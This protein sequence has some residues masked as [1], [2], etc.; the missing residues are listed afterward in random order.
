MERVDKPEHRD[1]IRVWLDRFKA[2]FGHARVLDQL[3]AGTI[4]QAE[5]AAGP[6][7]VKTSFLP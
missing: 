3:V 1:R 4:E 7:E 6:A 2:K 5:A